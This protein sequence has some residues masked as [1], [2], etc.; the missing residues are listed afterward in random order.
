[1]KQKGHFRVPGTSTYL[2]SDTQQYLSDFNV[3]GTFKATTSLHG[4]SEI[5]C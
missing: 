4:L 5:Q 1:M 2:V 3:T